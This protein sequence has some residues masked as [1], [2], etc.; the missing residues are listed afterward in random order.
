ML[1]IVEGIDF[2]VAL[3]DLLWKIVACLDCD[4]VL[5]K[6]F[7]LLEDFVNHK[8]KTCFLKNITEH[9]YIELDL[10]YVKVIKSLI[11]LI[12]GIV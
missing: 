10:V 9:E 11:E 1:M 5:L 2:V 3:V 8:R 6:E 12:L 7:M 4:M